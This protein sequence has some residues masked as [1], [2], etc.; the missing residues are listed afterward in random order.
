M[1][2]V[3][4]GVFGIIFFVF[5]VVLAIL[6]IMLP[7][8]VFAIRHRIDAMLKESRHTNAHLKALIELQGGV[9]PAAPAVDLYGRPTGVPTASPPA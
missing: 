8:A 2:S 6:W 4:G 5:L 1:G 7:F 3:F 9:A